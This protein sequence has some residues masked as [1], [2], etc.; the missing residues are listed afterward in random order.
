MSSDFPETVP[1]PCVGI[2][3][4]DENDVCM[5]CLRTMQEVTLWWDMSNMEKRELLKV[6][7]TRR[8]KN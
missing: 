4:P 7:P 6:L 2:C 8:N 1:S 5:G 3:C